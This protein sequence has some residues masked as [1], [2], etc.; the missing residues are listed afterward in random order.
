L[1]WTTQHNPLLDWVAAVPLD[2]AANTLAKVHLK[3]INV[4]W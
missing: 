2:A 4:A 3:N 1:Y